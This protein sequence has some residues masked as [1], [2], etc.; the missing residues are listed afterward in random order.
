MKRNKNHSKRKIWTLNGGKVLNWFLAV[1]A[2]LL[3]FIIWYTASKRGLI[4]RSILPSPLKVA[5]TAYQY[6][7]NGKLGKHLLISGVRVI[8]GFLTGMISGILIGTI[9]GLSKTIF[10]ILNT[11]VNL[12]RPIPMIAWIPLL[13]LWLGIG[14]ESKIAVIFIGSFWPVFLNTIHGIHS[15]DRKVIEVAN[16]LEKNRFQI[17]IEVIFPAATP[18]IFTGIRLGMGTAWTCVVAAEMIAASRGIGYLIAYA[19]ELSQPDVVLVGVFS[20]G[21]I[22]LLI[23]MGILRLQKHIL[24]W[25]DGNG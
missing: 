16:V 19:R 20:I 8:H 18:S 23:D 2:P 5:E 25:H 3:L 4:N 21:L 13:I 22:G 6:L 15:V 11:L 17:L 24:K 7:D 1:I 10:R 12:L 9:M 14:E